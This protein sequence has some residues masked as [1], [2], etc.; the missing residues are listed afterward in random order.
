M[1]QIIPLT[2][3]VIAMLFS[4]QNKEKTEEKQGNR[5]SLES[6]EYSFDNPIDSII[7]ST[8][9]DTRYDEV[10]HFLTW[11]PD[12][13]NNSKDVGYRTYPDEKD[14]APEMIWKDCGDIRVYFIPLESPWAG[15]CK[16]IVQFKKNG[17]LD[18]LSLEEID[19]KIE[20]LCEVKDKEGKT[21]YLL[22]TCL[23]VEHQGIV[24]WETIHAF[25]LG[26]DGLVQEKLFHTN[27][28]QYN[29]IKL[30]CG[31]QRW[32]PL[33]MYNMELIGMSGFDEKGEIPVVVVAVVNEKDWPTGYGLKSQWN[34]TYFEYV[35][36]CDYD[37]NGYL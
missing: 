22:K 19:G 5:D 16:N 26:K 28:G 33:D 11:H 17:K 32:C 14:Y 6:D 21:Y 2:I 27:N 10:Y 23:F 25:S 37:A 15:I 29:Q 8:E 12:F 7:Y 35:G 36:K 18:A 9:V 1:K 4:C 3:I 20:D 13:V 34:G 24:L 30:Q 31:G